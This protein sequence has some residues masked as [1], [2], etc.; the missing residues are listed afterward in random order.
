[1]ELLGSR[2]PSACWGS[3]KQAACGS[4]RFHEMG[5][6]RR[7]L[8]AERQDADAARVDLPG[9][10]RLILV[11]GPGFALHAADD[12]HAH[13]FLVQVLPVC[14]VAVPDFHRRPEAAAVLEVTALG[15]NGVVEIDVQ[16]QQAPR[17]VVA[18]GELPV[19]GGRAD[20]A[21][22]RKM[23]AHGAIS[24][25][26]EIPVPC[27]R[28]ARAGVPDAITDRAL[29]GVWTRAGA[30]RRLPPWR[31]CW[32]TPGPAYPGCATG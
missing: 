30:G 3:S 1:M 14:G 2:M 22:A 32:R 17:F 29:R 25:V 8:D 9:L 21:F 31:P 19:L 15:G 13:A 24:L 5:W 6:L 7:G 16:P 23:R 10:A 18:V 26:V 20:V 4:D 11:V 27:R 12:Q 28:R